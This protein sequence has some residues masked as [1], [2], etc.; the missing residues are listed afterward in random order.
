MPFVSICSEGIRFKLHRPYSKAMT[1]GYSSNDAKSL[2][3]W[4]LRVLS[5]TSMFTVANHVVCLV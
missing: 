1:W 2:P 4:Q 3:K 5:V